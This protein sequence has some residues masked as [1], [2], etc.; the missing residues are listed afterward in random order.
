MKTAIC[1]KPPPS[2]LLPSLLSLPLPLVLA[3]C[4]SVPPLFALV[5]CARSTDT[6]HGKDYH[7]APRPVCGGP[8]VGVWDM[9]TS[10]QTNGRADKWQS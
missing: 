6:A 3:C 9:Q 5:P 2:S 4:S 1:E 8:P 10:R 7:A